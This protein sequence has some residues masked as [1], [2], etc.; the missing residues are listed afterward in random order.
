MTVPRF[1]LLATACLLACAHAV[2]PVAPV[3]PGEDW[4]RAD[5]E[6]VGLDS[7]ILADAVDFAA[8]GD[9]GVHAMVVVRYGR[10]VL[11]ASVYPFEPGGKHDL[12]SCTKSLTSTLVGIAI[13]RK[14]MGGVDD[15]VRSFFPDH[16][17]SA[18]DARWQA[19]TVEHLLTMTSGM[20]CEEGGSDLSNV[21]A[22]QAAP[23]WAAWALDRPV[24]VEPGRRWQY[25]SAGSHLLSALLTA[26]T[27]RSAADLA[28]ERLFGPIGVTDVDWP[29]GRPADVSRGWGD[30]RMRPLDLA[31]VATLFLRGGRWGDAQVVG[32]SWVKTATAAHAVTGHTG[33]L[34]N[35]GYQW[36]VGDAFHGAVGR[37]GQ[38]ALVFPRQDLVVVMMGGAEGDDVNRKR[39][40]LFQSYLLR[41]LRRPDALPANPEGV[42]R[43]EAAVKAAVRPREGARVPVL[44]P[45]IARFVS[46]RAWVMSP[47]PLGLRGLTVTF[48]DASREARLRLD[49]D[50]G[51][52][53]DLAAGL[54]GV[55]RRSPGRYG[56]PAAARMVWDGE[57]LNVDLDEIGN[58]NRWRLVASFEG[59]RVTV[60]A[61]ERSGLP[62]VILVGTAK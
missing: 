10:V 1:S 41:A 29:A 55:A 11:D 6:S 16:P 52:S 56:L 27:G 42:R 26:K 45:E 4:V 35:Y 19:V 61:T 23:D 49:F 30:V 40:E 14:E 17:A 34:M 25:C 60:Q 62:P 22:M 48:P 15:K 9:F 59:D 47:N 2:P 32:E 50:D 43:L 46:G 12:A 8:G 28:R 33:P 51:G 18:G 53:I 58:I 21:M 54:D 31:R 44:L 7:D 24:D 5:P 57:T 3:F 37:G 38:F 13:D 20:R 36:W 39:L